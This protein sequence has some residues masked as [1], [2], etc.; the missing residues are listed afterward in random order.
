VKI[1]ATHPG[2]NLGKHLYPAKLPKGSKIGEGVAKRKNAKV[3]AAKSAV[4][5]TSKRKLAS[6]VKQ[7]KGI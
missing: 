5:K 2:K 7:M 1:K 6:V 3:V 4:V